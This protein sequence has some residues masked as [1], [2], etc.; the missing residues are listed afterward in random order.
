MHATITF[1]SNEH[2]VRR[3]AMTSLSA[4]CRFLGASAPLAIMQRGAKMLQLPKLVVSSTLPDSEMEVLLNNAFSLIFTSP[5]PYLTSYLAILERGH[6]KLS[7]CF[8]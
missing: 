2:H 1:L 7:S 3:M 4:G 8:T 5:I 6:P